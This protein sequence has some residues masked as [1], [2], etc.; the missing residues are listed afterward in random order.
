VPLVT[1]VIFGVVGI[2]ITG[3]LGQVAPAM[4]GYLVIRSVGELL[5]LPRDGWNAVPLVVGVN[6]ALYAAV[7][8]CLARRAKSLKPL[9]RQSCVIAAALITLSFVFDVAVPQAR[10]ALHLRELVRQNLAVVEAAPESIYALHWLGHHH[11]ARTGK[12]QDAERYFRRVLD[13]RADESHYSVYAQRCLIYLALIHLS[14]GKTGQAETEYRSFL[15]TAPDLADDLVLVYL[16]KLYM[17]M[18]ARGR[19]P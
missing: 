18:A 15:A 2:A 1:A 11:F 5:R 7:G 8:F 12:F 14:Q 3:A 6:G 9:L 10:D 13:A 19:V 4:G 16:N 17:D